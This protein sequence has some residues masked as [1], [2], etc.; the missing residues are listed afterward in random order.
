MTVCWSHMR[1]IISELRGGG[2]VD[3]SW[4]LWGPGLAAG[5]GASGATHAGT[6][7]RGDAT[8]ATARAD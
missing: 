3:G 5:A 2:G 8:S 6:S 7:A 1:D 4:W